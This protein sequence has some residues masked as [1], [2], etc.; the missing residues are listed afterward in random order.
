MAAAAVASKLNISISSPFHMATHQSK[1]APLDRAAAASSSRHQPSSSQLS[2][3]ASPENQPKTFKRFRHSLQQ[4]IR[5]ATKSKAVNANG[6]VHE[7]GVVVNGHG[8]GKERASEEQNLAKEKSKSSKMLSKVSFRRGP[9]RDSVSPSPVPP[10][11]LPT[12]D[13][14]QA[15]KLE[16]DRDKGRFRQAGRTSFETPSL[17][18]A[19]MSSPTL[20][21]SSQA[22]PSPYSQPF[23]LPAASSSNVAALVSPTRERSRRVTA[24][25]S[26]PS[27]ISGPLPLSPKR[28]G[29]GNG[30]PRGKPKDLQITVPPP[31]ASRYPELHDGLPTQLD[32][33]RRNRELT[34]SPDLSPPATPTPHSR[35]GNLA[36]RAAASTSHLPLASPPASPTTPRAVSPVRTRSSTR[37]PASPRAGPSSSSSHL[38]LSPPLSPA[39]RPSIDSPRRPSVETARRPSIEIRRPS[40]ET[41]RP[42]LDTQR[43]SP[44]PSRA[45]S[46]TTPIRPSRAVSPTQRNF[47]P[48]FGHNRFYNVNAS[49]ASLSVGNSGYNNPD[50][51]ELVRT[52]ASILIRD[53]LK[54]PSHLRDSSM[55]QEEYEEVELRLRN[56][57]RLERV[58]G[59]SGVNGSTSQLTSSGLSAGGED[60]ERR[61]FCDA[62]KDGYV[63]C[64][65][66]IR[67]FHASTLANIISHRFVNRLHSGYISKV[68][69]REENILKSS[70]NITRFLAAS[71]SLG[72]QP[73][74]LF[75]RD[76]LSEAT[77]DCLVRVA[78][79]IIALTQLSDAPA[80]D[81]SKILQGGKASPGPYGSSRAAA[82]T[83]NL[84]T[85]SRPMSPTAGG[86]KRMSPPVSTLP[87][88]RSDSPNESEGSSGGGTAV[89]P[90]A[91]AAVADSK[92]DVV[93]PM[94]PPPRS[95]LRNRPNVPSVADSLAANVSDSV[96]GSI[97]ES[98]VPSV[99]TRQS[100][101]STNVTDTTVYS[102]LLEV[103]RSSS[104]NNKF[105]TIRTVT[106]EATS[107]TPSDTPSVFRIDSA[108]SSP[109][110][111]RKRSYE[112]STSPGKTFRDR[113]PSETAIVD[114]TRVEEADE[115]G[116]S[117]NGKL[118]ETER[119]R[120]KLSNIRLGKGKW[121]DD[122]ID[123]FQYPKQSS[124]L[125]D[126]DSPAS[127]SHTPL[128][129]SPRKIAIVGAHRGN[130][131]LDSLPQFPRRP[132]HRSRH[133]ID[134]P[135]L[136]PRE[137]LL[138]RD[139]S[140]DS[141]LSPAPRIAIRRN[142]SRTSA[143][144]NGVYIP[145]NSDEP[146]LSS[147]DLVPFPRSVSGEHGTPP[148]Q[149][150]R[151]PSPITDIVKPASSAGVHDNPRQ[152]RGRFQSEIDG[153]SSRR[154]Q[155]PNS[156]DEMGGPRRRGRFESMVNLG[157]GSGNTSASDLLN[158]ESYGSA[159]RQT[160]IVKEDGKAPTQFVRHYVSERCTIADIWFPATRQLHWSRAVWCCV[161]RAEP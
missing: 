62:L 55:S 107:I 35:S 140:P 126:E 132:T 79:N 6:A 8:K 102:S 69:K 54:P 83:P 121:P 22:F 135:G 130:E 95:P 82:S 92:H 144:R 117:A 30:E 27:N 64:Q 125:D 119:E 50:H 72:V 141:S 154:K 80:P 40:I 26:R 115:S 32:S 57:A 138:P 131:S 19:S 88:V 14:Q 46:P 98:L 18:Q 156:Y 101:A 67:F 59:K 33:S 122:F 3:S 84:H 139:A 66:A 73:D 158:R 1:D 74:D 68:D 34:R 17:R 134:T 161:S 111:D 58:W 15:R 146:R 157:G 78:R 152:P 29:R 90:R 127:T 37:N 123:A 77:P 28:D 118:K 25:P 151:F 143:H 89:G 47:S 48:T 91:L 94:V 71:S 97:A 4:T 31:Q 38:P 44:T 5:T 81:K 112:P 56:L 20:H 110:E 23:A 13:R 114:L 155:R 16:R 65:C 120:P 60:R 160:L 124:A 70:N 7:D 93:P 85:M 42:S 106:T 116:S 109:I 11:H 147:D 43:P 53:L 9:A 105:G 103:Q 148:S 10:P 108:P 96:R 100:L 51:R 149:G 137:G 142:S 36:K 39:R 150:V 145:R 128:S 153:S 21:L 12:D 159:V 24:Q 104:Q 99:N 2:T 129:T 75:N 113:R 136:R 133:S 52:A 41:R 61:H 87:P 86:R 45:A 76:D 63:L 49:T